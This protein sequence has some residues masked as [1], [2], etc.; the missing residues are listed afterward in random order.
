MSNVVHPLKPIYDKNSEVLI[1]G[2]FPS[3]QSREKGF[4]Y[5]NP[6]NRF[7]PIMEKL[8]NETI[9]DKEEFCLRR[10]IALWDVIESCTIEGS[11]DASIKDVKPNDIENLIKDTNIKCIFTT[12]Y[13]AHQLFEKY[14]FV[15]VPCIGLPSTSSANAV[16]R[17]DEL[18]DVYNIILEYVDA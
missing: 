15:D 10:H 9:D 16:Y 1:L 14:I 2:S 11:N 3:V 12:G 17:L 4:Y 18:V 8:F 5:A 7:W 6:N 13:K